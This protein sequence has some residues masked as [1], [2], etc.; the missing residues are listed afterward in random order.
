MGSDRKVE[1]RSGHTRIVS[2]I[3]FLS[4]TNLLISVQSYGSLGH[5]EIVFLISL[6]SL[7]NLPISVQS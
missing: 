2:L 5:D 3:Y 6:L 1:G 4:L 7:T